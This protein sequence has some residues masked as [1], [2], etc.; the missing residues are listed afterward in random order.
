MNQTMKT[1]RVTAQFQHMYTI[2]ADEATYTCGVAGKFRFEATSERDYPVIGD[3]VEFI[4]RDHNQGTIQRLLERRTV[5]SRA[6][7]GNETKEQ[8][9]CANVDFILIMMACGHDFNVRRLERY[10][11]A[12]FDTGATPLVVLTKVD[13][14]DTVDSLVH[15]VTMT[16]P[17]IDVYPVSSLTGSGISTLRSVI[18][19]GSTIALVGS[20]GVGKSSLTNALAGT[21]LAVTQAV[22]SQDERGKHTTTHRALF[23]LDGLY[24]IDTP[25]MRE[26]GLWDGADHLDETFQDVEALATSCRFRDCSH[27]KEPGCAVQAAIRQGTLDSKRFASYV[28]LQRELQYAEKRQAE[29]QRIAEKKQKTKS[30]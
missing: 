25:G 21:T 7:A 22:R 2:T 10:A 30:R 20:S 18:P 8:L 15:D 28:K 12:A 4:V 9:I 6:A 29:A 23:K 14:S 11:L 16:V 19:D 26:F 17:G 27:H 5:L 13:Q 1:G 3:Y 24:V